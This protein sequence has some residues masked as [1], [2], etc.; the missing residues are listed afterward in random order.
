MSKIHID[1]LNLDLDGL[2]VI[3]ECAS[4]AYSL[5]PVIAALA[6]ANVY[7]VGRDSSYGTFSENK[8]QVE[9]LLDLCQP[10]GIVNFIEG[11]L[12]LDVAKKGDIFTNSGFLRPFN[13]EIISQMKQTAV[14][15][16]MWETWELR[17]GEIDLE[18]CKRNN[19]PVI[20]TNENYEKA[21]M[22]CYPGMIAL[23][24][25]FEAGLEIGNNHLVLLGAGLTGDL[26]AKT[27]DQLGISYNWYVE[28]QHANE[29]RKGYSRMKDIL[30]LDRLDGILCADH[31]SKKEI[32]GK[33]SS[34]QFNELKHTFPYLKWAHMMGPIDSNSLK[35]SG[36]YYFPKTIKP[37][38]Y[39][40]YET[41]NIGWE[42]VLLLNTAG[43]K[44]GEI[45]AQARKAGLSVD[46]SISA[47][48]KHGVGQDFKGG[49][50]N[51]GR[52]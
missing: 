48:V 47:S 6:G 36:L 24:L 21:D 5:T 44:V 17:D 16:L 28:D 13:E 1:R 8:T 25:L 14:I 4:Q 11:Q 15:C 29:S 34:I 30:T 27:F 42:P 23:K 31:S 32:I 12:P 39:M 26:I 51:Y 43:L 45:T 52:N 10:K 3:T 50:M 18:A 49:F 2:T 7:A 41:I 40:S 33:H 35:E 37:V 19:I 20:G 46:E 22:F 9:Q 38:G